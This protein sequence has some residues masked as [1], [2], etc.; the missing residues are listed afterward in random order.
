ME[1]LTTYYCDRNQVKIDD[2]LM[3]GAATYHTEYT[4]KFG[5][6]DENYSIHCEIIIREY[7][8]P[9]KYET[10][11]Y[12]IRHL[13]GFEKYIETVINVCSNDGFMKQFNISH[14][15]DTECMIK[16][17]GNPFYGNEDVI[18]EKETDLFYGNENVII[19]EEFY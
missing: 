18:I 16:S 9:R 6:V 12:V 11:K 3:Y 17:E 14:L 1:R 13:I 15:K 2:K 19:E 8:D 5:I 7:Y 4:S 10:V